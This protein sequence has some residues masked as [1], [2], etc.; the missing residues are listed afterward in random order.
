MAT[1]FILERG[2]ASVHGTE[3][4]HI[5]SLIDE[6][7]PEILLEK[8]KLL[9]IEKLK[10]EISTYKEYCEHYLIKDKGYFIYDDNIRFY[11]AGGGQH[12]NTAEFVVKTI[13]LLVLEKAIEK[14]YMINFRSI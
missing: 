14:E 5:L 9:G 4:G 11:T 10:P 3:I 1:T 8:C 7:A 2:Y 12:R 6:I 13:C